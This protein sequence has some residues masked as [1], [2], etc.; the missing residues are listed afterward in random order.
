M[1]ILQQ[2]FEVFRDLIYN[3]SGIYLSDK[4]K[5]IFEN[6]IQKRLHQL[7]IDT[8][9]D[10]LSQII[11]GRTNNDE[12]NYLVDT[13]TV[14][15]TLFFR[16]MSQLRAFEKVV[17][18]EILKNKLNVEGGSIR[19]LSAGC[20]SGEEPY[21]IAIILHDKFQKEMNTVNLEIVGMDISEQILNEARQGIF[22]AH[23][24][25]EV[26]SYFREKY[27]SRVDNGYHLSEDIVKMVKF[28]IGNLM[29]EGNLHLLGNFDI[30]FCRNVLIY[31]DRNSKA[32]A[33]NSLSNLLNPGGFLFVG[34][35]ESLHG[36]PHN[37]KLI[38][39]QNA[40]GYQKPG[41]PKKNIF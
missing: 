13:I 19:I 17:F 33:L 23:A 31:F 9:E 3:K 11:Q 41:N 8:Y 1:E 27:F 40:M 18:P 20:S 12:V 28:Q 21:T 39:F 24:L 5:K 35:S 25:Q 38:H 36:I 7:K 37:L 2:T 10:Y 30:I 14:K 29:D 6:R 16:N 32:R 22:S 34:R 26:D 4:N 15:E